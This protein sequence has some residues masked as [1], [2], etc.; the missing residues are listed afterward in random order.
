[1]N[2]RFIA[3]QF[4][5]FPNLPAQ[6]HRADGVD[7]DER[8]A[9]GIGASPAPT[10]CS[11]VKSLTGSGRLRTTCQT[12]ALSRSHSVSAF[13]SASRR[14]REAMLLVPLRKGAAPTIRESLRRPVDLFFDPK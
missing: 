13:C 11:E 7:A 9:V 1:M 10:L 12:P 8:E 2:R 5:Q 4:R 6:G 3:V 14:N